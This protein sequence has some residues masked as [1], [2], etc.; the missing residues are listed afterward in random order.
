[1]LISSV[2][3]L[4]IF[5]LGFFPPKAIAMDIGPTLPKYMVKIIIIFPTL[6]SVPVKPR[7]SPTV[8]VALTVSYRISSAGASVTAESRR[9][10]TSIT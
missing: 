10:D 2:G 6:L 1:M 7:E 3:F 5:R 4:I 9:V 8:A